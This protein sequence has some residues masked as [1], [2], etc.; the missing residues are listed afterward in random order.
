MKI[1]SRLGG[2]ELD[3]NLVYDFIRC[4]SVYPVGT[5]VELS[6]AQLTPIR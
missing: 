2:E 1:L 5:M 3:I 4:M 6:T